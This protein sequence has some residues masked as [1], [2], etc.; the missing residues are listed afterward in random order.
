MYHGV[1]MCA[2]PYGRVESYELRDIDGGDMYVFS[3]RRVK[4]KKCWKKS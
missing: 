4:Q 1:E 2:V 3:R